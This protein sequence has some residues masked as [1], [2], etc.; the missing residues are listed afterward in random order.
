MIAEVTRVDYVK[1][2]ILRQTI[3]TEVQSVPVPKCHLNEISDQ[4]IYNNIIK[5]LVINNFALRENIIGNNE[6][7]W[8]GHMTV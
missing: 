3:A 8:F 6:V 4:F 5:I 1:E 2:R 7:P